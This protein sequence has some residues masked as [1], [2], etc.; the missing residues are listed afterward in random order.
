MIDAGADPLARGPDGRAALAVAVSRPWRKDEPILPPAVL[1]VLLAGAGPLDDADDDGVPMIELAARPHDDPA[2]QEAAMHLVARLVDAGAR[3]P[4]ARCPSFSDPMQAALLLRAGARLDAP[5]P[6]GSL[7]I[8]RAVRAG[9]T[10]LVGFLLERGADANAVD[11]LG[12]TALGVCLRTAN[13][14]WVRHHGLTGAFGAIE[15]ALEAAG[16]LRSR[17]FAWVSGDPFAPRPIDGVALRE[18]CGDPV[19]AAF[20]PLLARENDSVQDLVAELRHGGEH[21]RALK[22]LAILGATLGEPRPFTIEGDLSIQR[23]FFW[24]GDLVVTGHLELRSPA[25]ITGN[26]SVGGAVYDAMNDSRVTIGGGLRC[27]ALF[28]GGDFAVAADIVATSFVWGHHND[29]ILAASAIRAPVVI[30]EDHC[31]MADVESDAH[32]DMDTFGTDNEEVRARLREI[33]VDE[34][35]DSDGSIDRRG[36]FRRVIAGGPVLR[37][38]C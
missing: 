18:A 11:G 2:T 13:E 21:L 5:D 1:A 6:R 15:R 10:Q 4:P 17:A 38:G 25:A 34:V 32:F 35:F 37:K 28:T 33:F 23:P 9:N 12:R 16:G 29:F 22:L 27:A 20:A 30:E 8:H 19:L 14:P 26:L 36:V 7:P 31:T 24:H 3:F